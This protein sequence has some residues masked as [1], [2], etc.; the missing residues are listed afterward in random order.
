VQEVHVRGDVPL[1]SCDRC[2]FVTGGERFLKIHM[3]LCHLGKEG[4][5]FVCPH[6]GFRANREDRLARHV[7][8]WHGPGGG[9][10]EEA[11]AGIS[12]PEEGSS[13]VLGRSQVYDGVGFLISGRGEEGKSASDGQEGG[14]GDPVKDMPMVGKE[15]GHSGGKGDPIGGQVEDVPVVGK[16]EGHGGSKGDL[17]DDRMED[18]PMGK[19]ERSPIKSQEE[20]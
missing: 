6:C 5:T 9:Q 20:V 4:G 12:G 14:K 7:A 19:E 3:T 1:V 18:A 10:G 17:V 15:E 8:L 2:H 13:R 11:A 16:E